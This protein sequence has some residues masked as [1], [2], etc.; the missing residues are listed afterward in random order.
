MRIRAQRPVS[1]MLRFMLL[2]VPT[3]RKV[4]D[5][6]DI[7]AFCSLNPPRLGPL[8]TNDI[9]LSSRI[10]RSVLVMYEHMQ[11]LWQ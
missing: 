9:L 8:L 11:H 5:L 4:S 7:N 10:N 2:Y 1:C 6:A 3:Y